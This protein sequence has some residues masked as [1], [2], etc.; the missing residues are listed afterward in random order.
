[1]GPNHDFGTIRLNT[2]VWDLHVIVTDS[3]GRRLGGS[4]AVPINVSSGALAAAPTAGPAPASATPTAGPAPASATPV[5]GAPAPT[6]A[7]AARPIGSAIAAGQLSVAQELGPDIVAAWV[8]HQGGRL[9]IALHT[10]N[11]FEQPAAI[12]ITL[13]HEPVVGRCGLG[14]QVVSVPASTSTLQVNAVLGGHAYTAR[15]PVAFSAGAGNARAAAIMRQLGTGEARLRSVAAVERLASSPTAQERIVDR[16]Q[17]PDRYAYQVTLN[18]RPSASTVIVGA[19]EWNRTPGQP[20]QASTFG[21]Q[22]FSAPSLLDWWVGYASAPRLLDEHAAGGGEIADVATIGE[23]S[24]LGPVWLR[25][26]IDATRS[27]LLSASMIT[28]AHFMTEAWSDFDRVPAI[29]P[30]AG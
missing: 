23:I 11:V 14:C 1:L 6:A 26:H 17:A 10:L 5:P 4:F 7:K 22:P 16:I 13:P 24:G 19:S 3:A 29:V 8:S 18:G 20:W 27:R 30:P 21:T 2:G 28:V 9:R 12:A 15:L 25:L